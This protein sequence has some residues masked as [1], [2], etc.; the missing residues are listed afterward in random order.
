MAL[1]TI[2]IQTTQNVSIDYDLA[3]V[4][5]RIGA[6]LIDLVI[7][8]ILFWLLILALDGLDVDFEESFLFMIG[9]LTYMIF[10]F[11]LFETFNR[12]QT[13]GKKLIGLKVIR[14]DGR[15]PTPGDFLAR[16]IFL[17]VDVVFTSG[18]AAILLIA[19][20][21]NKQR[22]GDMSAGTVVIQANTNSIFSLE[23]I[24][25]IKNRNDYEPVFPGVQRFTDDDM[26][27]VKQSLNRMRKY[28]NPAH[29]Q[30][31]RTL[32]LHL[33]GLLD[34]PAN[35]LK[36]TPEKFLE[37]ILLDYIVITR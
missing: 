7:L 23:E 32:A 22:L 16:A 33:A 11:F 24:M 4:G 19:S 3:K 31:V 15:D 12:G 14:R 21:K 10:Y 18:I 25:N 28:N 1:D 2:T 17:L 34:L 36:Y 30:A 29:R 27:I 5:A 37:T 20:G 35:E 9:P 26:M 13:P 8:I 6:F